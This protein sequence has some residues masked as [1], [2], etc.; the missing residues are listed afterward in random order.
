MRIM[1]KEFCQRFL[2]Y[3]YNVLMRLVKDKLA[4]NKAQDNDET[5]FFWSM[6]FFLEFNRYLLSL[7]H[8]FLPLS[9]E[10]IVLIFRMDTCMF[11]CM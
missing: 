10:G 8:S 3:G 5:Y 6:S 2:E 7:I 9:K 1:L 11:V 4:H